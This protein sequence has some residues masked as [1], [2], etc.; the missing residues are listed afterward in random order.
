MD[1]VGKTFIT[2]KGETVVILQKRKS[3]TFLFFEEF[4]VYDIL[5]NGNRFSIKCGEINN[6]LQG[7]ATNFIFDSFY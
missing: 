4:D 5:L 7:K 6:L 2:S 1:L 3:R